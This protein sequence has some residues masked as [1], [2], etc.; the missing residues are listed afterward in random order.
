M[1]FEKIIGENTVYKSD[2]PNSS[3]NRQPVQYLR[4]GALMHNNTS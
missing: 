2:C 3:K 1:I 4:I